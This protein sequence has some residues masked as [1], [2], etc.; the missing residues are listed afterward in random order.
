M[1]LKYIILIF[2][3]CTFGCTPRSQYKITGEKIPESA[4]QEL[5]WS[6]SQKNI[7]TFKFLSKTRISSH[8]YGTS[9][10]RHALV[11][12]SD[13]SVDNSFL[14][15]EMFPLNSALSLGW[16]AVQ[17]KNALF[18]D[19]QAKKAYTSDNPD[20]LLRRAIGIWIPTR[21]AANL[22]SARVPYA[23][24]R[25]ASYFAQAYDVFNAGDSIEIRGANGDLYVL[26]AQTHLLTYVELVTPG[27]KKL[28][29]T[30]SYSAFKEFQGQLFPS[31]VNLSVP[32]LEASAD[33]D[34]SL[35]A[36]A[37]G[38]YAERLFNI[39]APVGYSLTRVK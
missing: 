17:N 22:L 27:S 19:T 12:Q 34:I 18:V 33:L 31:K 14:R 32:K 3:L 29:T 24:V 9:T 20:L 37:D 36:L 8:E 4:E 7:S 23:I 10:I 1:K 26:D 30:I 16:L 39:N 21:R 13:S 35:K 15:I 11:A 38:P 5:A 2:L 6:L 25:D 28:Q